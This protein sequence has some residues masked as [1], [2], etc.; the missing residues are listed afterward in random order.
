MPECFFIP[1]TKPP[2]SAGSRTQ[3]G[4]GDFSLW[5]VLHVLHP[6]G[7]YPAIPLATASPRKAKKPIESVI[8]V[9]KTLLATAGS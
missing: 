2:N 6:V 4:P 1:F 5:T 8:M 7:N 3:T 9:T